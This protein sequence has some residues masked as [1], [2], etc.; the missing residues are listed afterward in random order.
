MRVIAIDRQ[1]VEFS[2]CSLVANTA[3]LLVILHSRLP[4]LSSIIKTN[5]LPCSSAATTAFATG[6]YLGTALSKCSVF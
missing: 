1:V 3:P 2:H 4:E 5:T 6:T